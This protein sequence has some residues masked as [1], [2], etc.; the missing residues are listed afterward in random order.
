VRFH[1]HCSRSRRQ[2]TLLI[3]SFMYLSSLSSGTPL[4]QCLIKRIL[5]PAMR[6][7]SISLRLSIFTDHFLQMSET[8]CHPLEPFEHR[9]SFCSSR[10]QVLNQNI[11]PNTRPTTGTSSLPLPSWSLLPQLMIYFTAHRDNG[12]KHS[13]QLSPS[14]RLPSF[15]LLKFLYIPFLKAPLQ[16]SNWPRLFLPL[17]DDVYPS[18]PCS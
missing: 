14:S 7:L 4:Q 16:Q 9:I 3:S 10:G 2:V 18:L 1:L 15:F 5:L 13:C 8:A 17:L 11:S 6:P 12:G